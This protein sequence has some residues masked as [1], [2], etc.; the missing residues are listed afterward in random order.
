M[1]KFCH[2]ETKKLRNGNLI[3]NGSD[4]FMFVKQN[5]PKSIRFC[6]KE[7]NL[8]NNEID[9]FLFHQA[10]KF[11]V[12]ELRKDLKISEEKSPFLISETGNLV[13]TTI[14]F[15]INQYFDILKNKQIVLSG[16]GVGLTWATTLLKFR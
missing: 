12:E 8:E 15:L 6:L 5:V 3:M 2:L 1:T 7:A 4:I 11:V 13:S 14:P 16:F 9:F 10:S